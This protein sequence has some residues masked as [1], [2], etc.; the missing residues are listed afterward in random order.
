MNP[1][2]P[3]PQTPL[4][5]ALEQ[6]L[7]T[8][9][10]TDLNAAMAHA[11]SLELKLQEAKARVKD[12]E[13][14]NRYQRGY[15][16]GEKSMT[17]KLQEAELLI[18]GLETTQTFLENENKEFERQRDEARKECSIEK[19][20]WI[21]DDRDLNELIAERDQLIKVV[22]ELAHGI[23]AFLDSGSAMYGTHYEVMIKCYEAYSL[24]PHVQAKNHENSTNV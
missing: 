19:R 11:R 16:A 12:L 10:I 17:A 3:K 5:D 4:T 20:H 2:E 13:S 24:L 18:R 22:D 7:T 14:N 21:E 1:T 15:D 8:W 6:S 9:T 23:K